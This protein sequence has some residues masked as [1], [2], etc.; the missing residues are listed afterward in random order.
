MRGSIRRLLQLSVLA[1]VMIV[2]MLVAGGPAL[3]ADS[4]GGASVVER[5]GS[6]SVSGELIE[7]RREVFSETSE[8]VV[9]RVVTNDPRVNG[10]MDLWVD[11]AWLTKQGEV[12]F[13]GFWSMKTRTGTW[14]D[15]HFV[16]IE[17]AGYLTGEPF[18]VT[19]LPDVACGGGG[20]RG[21]VLRYR[22]Y[23]AAGDDA[24]FIMKGSITEAD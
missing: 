20:N 19:V 14:H 11:D 22:A 18:S 1:L 7:I 3:A 21:L 24:E 2:P 13:S 8:H 15:D 12:A 23:K 6:S 9:Y 10:I 5:R 16:G 4:S 17:S